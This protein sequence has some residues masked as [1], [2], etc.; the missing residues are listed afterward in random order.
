MFIGGTQ[1][2][3]Y[4]ELKAGTK[5]PREKLDTFVTEIEKLW[6]EQYC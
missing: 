3:K 1:M 2:N 4:I 5:V 6:M